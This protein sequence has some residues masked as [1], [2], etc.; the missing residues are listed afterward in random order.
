MVTTCN[1]LVFHVFDDGSQ[2]NFHYYLPRDRWRLT[3]LYFSLLMFFDLLENR[4]DIC[5]FPQ[6]T[7]TFNQ[8]PDNFK[9]NQKR[10]HND[11]SQFFHDYILSVQHQIGLDN[12][13]AFSSLNDC[14]IRSYG[15]VSSLATPLP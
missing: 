8:T 1:H 12:L 6:F 7:G 10:P 2:N 4:D 11:I 5:F 15:L 9:G 3:S 14:V 13:R